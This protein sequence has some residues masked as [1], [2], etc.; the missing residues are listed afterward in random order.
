MKIRKAKIEDLDAINKV[1]VSGC[2]DEVRLQHPEMSKGEVLKEMKRDEVERLSSFKKELKNPE[3][4]WLVAEIEGRIIGFS[5]AK[6]EKTCEKLRGFWEKVYIDKNFRKKG[7]GKI[8]GK[9]TINW[10]K[11]KKA[12]T[13]EGGIFIKNKPSIALCKSLG[14]KPV[15]VR[16]FMELK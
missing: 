7:I 15:A 5:Q 16:M 8:F 12:K 3:Y 4:Y 6:V 1:Y 2:I 14:L 9:D 11:K 10:L 13:V